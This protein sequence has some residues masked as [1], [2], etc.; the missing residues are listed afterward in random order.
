MTTFIVCLL[1]FSVVCSMTWISRQSRDIKRLEEENET[2]IEYM[3]PE[4]K[5]IL[6]EISTDIRGMRGEMAVMKVSIEKIDRGVYGDKDNK[7]PGLIDRQ[8]SDEKRIAVLEKN[9][10]SKKTVA[11][12]VAGL[13]SIVATIGH[14]IKEFIK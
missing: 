8:D 10:V 7:T 11:A 9:M 6:M 14:T 5:A 3:E 2:L 13:S 12:W 4:A 1:I